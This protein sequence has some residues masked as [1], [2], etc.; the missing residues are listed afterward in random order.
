[1]PALPPSSSA[2]SPVARKEKLMKEMTVKA[3][4]GCAGKENT[5]NSEE[6]LYVWSLLYII[7]LH[8]HT[9]PIIQAKARMVLVRFRIGKTI[10]KGQ[11]WPR[12]PGE[13]EAD[14]FYSR[15]KSLV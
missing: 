15:F 14:R 13:G 7:H 4:N 12:L 6:Y 10:R 5:V 1:M 2:M 3:N 8:I 11:V 9:H